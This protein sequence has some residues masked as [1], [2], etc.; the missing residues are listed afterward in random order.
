MLEQYMEAVAADKDKEH[1]LAS[2]LEAVVTFLGTPLHP[3][4]HCDANYKAVAQEN[5]ERWQ[6]IE[7]YKPLRR[8]P[9]LF[10]P[11][12][13]VQPDDFAPAFR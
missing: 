3:C 9:R 12:T 10:D 5:H 13:F 6:A 2:A 8:H 1:S 7:G 4:D 11:T